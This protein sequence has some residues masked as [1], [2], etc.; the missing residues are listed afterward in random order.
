[1]HPIDSLY[2]FRQVSKVT[3]VNLKF[4]PRFA[5]FPI[6]IASFSQQYINLGAEELWIIVNDSTLPKIETSTT[7]A[8]TLQK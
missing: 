3:H 4:F 6:H 5:L 1:M 8:V 7:V 2:K